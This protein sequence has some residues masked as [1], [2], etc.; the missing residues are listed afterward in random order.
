MRAVV[1]VE[2][3][4]AHTQIEGKRYLRTVSTSL[5]VLPPFRSLED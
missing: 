3:A 5:H 2:R 1:Y 4:Q